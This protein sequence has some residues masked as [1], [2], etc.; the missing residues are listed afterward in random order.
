M[1]ID[2]LRKFLPA[3]VIL[4]VVA[5]YAYCL[6]VKGVYPPSHPW[7]GI[8]LILLSVGLAGW[9]HQTQLPLWMISAAAVLSAGFWTIAAIR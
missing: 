2:Q 9:R 5:V 6:G 4:E 7:S 3:V 8:S 1:L